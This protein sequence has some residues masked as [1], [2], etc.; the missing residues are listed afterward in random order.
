MI[1]QIVSI[2]LFGLFGVFARY[3]MTVVVGRV[4]PAP[5]PVATFLINLLGAF[6]VGIFYVIGIEKGAYSQEIRLGVMIG[7]LGGFTT[8]ST[9]SLESVRLFEEGEIVAAL[10]YFGL[11]PLLGL[12]LTFCGILLARRLL[13]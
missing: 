10:L 3:L 12:L 2:G 7:F 5:F 11:S 1:P 9:Y 8:F 6:L 13:V 4:F